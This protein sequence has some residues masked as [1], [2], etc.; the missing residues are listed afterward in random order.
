MYKDGTP[1]REKTLYNAD[2]FVED[3]Q[4]IALQFVNFFPDLDMHNPMAL[5]N[6]SPLPNNPVLLYALFY[7]GQRVDMG[8]A[9][10]GD[11]ISYEEYTFIVD[12]PT[13]YTVLQVNHDPGITWAALGGLLQIIGLVLAFYL[14]PK[15]IRIVAHGG[16]V[17]LRAKSYGND[18]LFKEEVTNKLEKWE[19]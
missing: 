16:I 11:E 12:R 5:K 1:Y 8:L 14:K 7:D 19:K 3:E 17:W 15:E 13:M 4:K 6:N 10:M 2:F 18:N 9:R